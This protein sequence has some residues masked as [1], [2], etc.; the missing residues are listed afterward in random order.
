[1]SGPRGFDTRELGTDRPDEHD[2][3]LAAAMRLEASMIE[4]PANA[5]AGLGDRVMAALA[6]EPA[7][8]TVGFLAPVRRRG[9]LAGFAASVRQAWASLGGE[10]RPALTRASA[11]AYVL[12]IAIAG[13]SLAGAATF[14]VAGALGMLG[15]KATETPSLET[16]APSTLPE[17]TQLQSPQSVPPEVTE[18]PGPSE[19]AEV[20]DDHGDGSVP[21]PSDDDGG[22]SGLEPS[23]DHGDSPSGS[24][25][26]E[27]ETPSPTRTP[28]PSET[29]D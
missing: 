12:A 27:S 3:A 5:S 6:D 13:T 2:D 17:P 4:P 28:K 1:M 25:D 26:S 21:E 7:P 29:P 20:S 14:G 19:S 24:D 10:G 23:D 16:P 22:S 15:P 9:L 18:S 11:L 8:S